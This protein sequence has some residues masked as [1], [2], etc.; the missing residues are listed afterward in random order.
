MISKINIIY[1]NLRVRPS[2]NGSK[3]IGVHQFYEYRQF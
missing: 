2:S 3:N 1:E